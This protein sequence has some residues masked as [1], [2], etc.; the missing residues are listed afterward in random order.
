MGEPTRATLQIA[1]ERWNQ[2][3]EVAPGFWIIATRHRPGYSRHQPE[4]NNRCLVFRLRDESAGNAEVLVAVNAVDL[5]ALAEVQRLETTLGVP[6]RYVVA[7]GGGHVVM[8]PEWHDKLPNARILVGPTRV[9]RTAQ[10]KKLATSSR[11][12]VFDTNDPLPQFRGQLEAVNFDGLLGFREI[13]TPKEGGKDSVFGM[14]KVMLTE[15]PPKDPTDEL[16]L[17]HVASRTVIGGENLGWI[18]SKQAHTEMPFMMRMMMK[19]EQLYLMS[20]PRKVADAARASAHWKAILGWPAETVM[21]YH[22]TLG[23]AFTVGA[24]EALENAVRAAKQL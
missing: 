22:D 10:G 18:L 3:V 14:L 8:L 9:P 13:K 11:F 2:A 20:G 7:P 19:P 16:W 15:M 23:S 17:Y 1:Q 6:L 4:I 5:A 21:T 24:H 12:K